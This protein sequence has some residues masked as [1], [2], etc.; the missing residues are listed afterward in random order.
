MAE[1]EREGGFGLHISPFVEAIDIGAL[2]QRAG[3]K[4]L[5]IDHDR[6]TICYPTMFELMVDLKAMGENNATW[7]RKPHLNRDSMLAAAAI[8]KHF[9][10]KDDGTIPA[11]FY[12]YYFIGWKHDESQT[13]EAKRGSAT[14]S[15]KD[16]A[17]L[18][19]L[20]TGGSKS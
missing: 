10:G 18:D 19:K 2:L 20:T 14:F 15:L 16:I 4:L 13:K 8:Y 17:N 6:F 7:N 12:V 11:S 1:I 3:F 9:Y 5:T